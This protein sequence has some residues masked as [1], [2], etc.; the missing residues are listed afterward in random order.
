MSRSSGIL[1]GYLAK[2]SLKRLLEARVTPPPL[3]TSLFTTSFSLEITSINLSIATIR[4]LISFSSWQTG[5]IMWKPICHS[6]EQTPLDQTSSVA[7]HNQTS[8]TIADRPFSLSLRLEFSPTLPRLSAHIKG[9]VPH[10]LWKEA[11]MGHSA[12]GFITT[13]SGMSISK[14]LNQP[15]ISCQVA[16]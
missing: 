4:R 8:P 11:Q 16:L 3:R 10:L 12:C 14:C 15:L 1:Y 6:G 13:I 9:A 5:V 2:A 7:D